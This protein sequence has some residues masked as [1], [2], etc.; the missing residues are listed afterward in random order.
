MV[1]LPLQ[2]LSYAK[3]QSDATRKLDG[4]QKENMKEQRKR[5]RAVATGKH[6]CKSSAH[7]NLSAQKGDYTAI[8]STAKMSARSL[9][10]Q[11]WSYYLACCTVIPVVI[12]VLM[13]V[14]TPDMHC[15]EQFANRAKTKP[16]A[17]VTGNRMPQVSC[18]IMQS[19]SFAPNE[20]ILLELEIAA[21]I[22]SE[23]LSE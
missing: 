23:H 19:L 15:A 12:L 21:C 8:T 1:F 4:T 5:Q 22:P 20:A 13:F 14:I 17:V 2:R 10:R 18:L 16:S 11:Y 3:E 6:I 9:G 7:S